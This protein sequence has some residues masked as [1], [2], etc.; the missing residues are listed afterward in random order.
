MDGQPAEL[1]RKLLAAGQSVVG[2]DP[3][4]VGEAIDPAYPV[5][6]PPRHGSF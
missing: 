2:F 1:V 4:F 5:P 6:P 3:L